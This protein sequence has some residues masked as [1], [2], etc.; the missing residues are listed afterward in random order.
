MLIGIFG[1]IRGL[2]EVIWYQISIDVFRMNFY[3]ELYFYEVIQC[4]F[5]C[6]LYV[7]VV[8]YFVSGYVQG[9]ND[10]VSLFW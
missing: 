9:I 10:F 1:R 4:F 5:E 6:I 8:C 3:I 7:W 2:D